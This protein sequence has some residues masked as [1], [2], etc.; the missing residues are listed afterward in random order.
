M[1]TRTLRVNELI[2]RELS[3]LLRKRHQEEAACI[4]LTGVEVTPDT[5][6]GR[7]FVAVTGDDDLAV[8]KLRWLRSISKDLRF[9]LGRLI[10]LRHMPVLRFEIDVS[11]PRGNRILGIM[12]DLERAPKAPNPPPGT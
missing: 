5:K 8:A 3:A 7:V 1:S 9:E 6:E 11:T 12:D 4:T 10:V 2:H